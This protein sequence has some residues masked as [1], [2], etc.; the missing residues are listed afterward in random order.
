MKPLTK[1]TLLFA[2]ML[3]ADPSVHA[4]TIGSVG[5]VDGPSIHTTYF[6]TPNNAAFPVHAIAYAGTMVN[7]YCQYNAV[8]DLGTDKLKSG[9]F[10]DIDGYLLKSVVGVY[11][12]LTVQYTYRQ[13]AMETF[14]LIYNGVN[15]ESS[16]PAVT[17]VTIL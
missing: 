10:V 6:L 5:R 15:Y 8:Y 4:W 17:Q 12:C 1:W 7:G 16:V 9:D 13:I 11:G 14:Q 2:A 3:F